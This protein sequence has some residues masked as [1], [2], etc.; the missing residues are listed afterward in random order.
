MKPTVPRHARLRIMSDL[1]D[2]EKREDVS[3]LF[4]VESGSRA[5]GFPSPDSDYDARFV[6]VRPVD[7][8]LKLTRGRDVI[9]RPIDGLFDTNGWDLSKALSLLLKPNPVLLEW[10][11]SPIRYKWTDIVCEQLRDFASRTAYAEAC[12]HHYAGVAQGQWAQYIDGRDVVSLKRYF[13][14]VRPA[15]CLR[16]V[17][18]DRAG[19][20]PMNIYDL[21]ASVELPDGFAAEIVALLERKAKASELGEGR[22]IADL[23][24]FIADQLEW[25]KTFRG[26]RARPA[27]DMRAEADELF[28]SIVR[29]AAGG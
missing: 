28:V 16:W 6:Y 26:A 14:V 12:V 15:L 11:A 27:S 24:S 23:D 1:A 7:W 2:I 3:V 18:E 25:A 13:Y 29:G 10:L 19:A 17:R 20:P 21:M 4:A 8:Y 5:W 22:R 9:E